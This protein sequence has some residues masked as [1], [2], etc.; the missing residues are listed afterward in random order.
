MNLKIVTDTA[1]KL[2]LHSQSIAALLYVNL[3]VKC[4]F[5]SL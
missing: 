2:N 5:I 3:H 4:N 1:R